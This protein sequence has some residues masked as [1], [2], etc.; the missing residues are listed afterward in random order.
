VIKKDNY[1]M[2]V[3]RS[4]RSGEVV[5]PIVSE[6][7]FVRMKPLATPALEAVADGRI[8]I[9]PDRF[10]RVYNNW[11]ENI[12]DWCISRQLWWGHRIPVYY[13]HDSEAAAA[14]SEDGVSSRYVVASSM[15]EAS[16]LAKEK[17]GDG[18]VLR[19][20]QDVL[21]TW[22]SSGL[23]PFSTLGWPNAESSDLKTF[24]PTQMMETG[25]DI[26]F[27]WVSRMIMMGMHL[28]GQVPFDTVYLHGLVRD[29][30]GRKMSKSLGNVVDPIE[31]ISDCG[32]DAL[33]FTLA[34]GSAV[35]QDLN[36]SMERLTANRNFVNKLWNAGKYV[37]LML[38]K[39]D[40][41][42]WEAAVSADF[43][44]P[45]ELAKLPL[46]ERWVVSLLHQTIDSVTERFDKYDYNQ[47]GITTYNFFWDEFADWAIEASKPRTYG[48][49]AAAAATS[50][51][52]LVYVF[53][54]VLR[55]LHPYMP[56]V[57]EELWQALPHSGDALILAQWPSQG[58]PADT[59]ALAPSATRARS[60][61]S[62]RS[63]VSPPRWSCLTC[64]CG[65]LWR[66]SCRPL[67]CWQSW[68][69][70][71]SAWCPRRQTLVLPTRSRWWCRTAWSCCCPWPGCLTSTRRSSAWT[72]RGRRL[73]RT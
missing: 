56:F 33:R 68:T 15:Q 63:G 12:K 64:R 37:L 19:Q 17:Y 67:R 50:R 48:D 9:L 47:A 23:W 1:T 61:A 55:L 36:L 5:E 58:L 54:R 31:V 10:V 28:T 24:Y 16:M 30:K 34:T 6:Q 22:F 49:A 59:V 39:A 40:E 52:V 21:D 35:G 57:T 46:S 20:D 3:P 42:E 11:L 69:Q 73:R 53:E 2:R 8:T 26:L 13:V 65:R 71:Q 72:S 70:T 41:T 38:S 66:A 25:H 60:T 32:T 27:F 45:E 62:R 51:R 7:W 18:V 14:A 44:K 29:E 4:Q 43:S